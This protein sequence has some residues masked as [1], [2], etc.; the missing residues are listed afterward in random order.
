MVHDCG[1]VSSYTHTHTHTTNQPCS[2]MYCIPAPCDIFFHPAVSLLPPFFLIHRRV[3][4]SGRGEGLKSAWEIDNTFRLFAGPPSDNQNKPSRHH[5]CK[6]RQIDEKERR[7][8]GEV[9]RERAH[10]EKVCLHPS[11]RPSLAAPCVVSACE[12]RPWRCTELESGD[13]FFPFIYTISIGTVGSI[14]D[15]ILHS[16]VTRDV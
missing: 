12:R 1:V 8:R 13:Y 7:R 3:Q 16:T 6:P 15:L 9:R 5:H 2:A 4:R 10:G 14:C 11:V